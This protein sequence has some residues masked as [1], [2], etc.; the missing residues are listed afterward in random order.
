MAT[1]GLVYSTLITLD[2][3]SCYFKKLEACADQVSVSHTLNLLI[4]LLGGLIALACLTYLVVFPW[5]V[6]GCAV[7]S[8]YPLLNF[9]D[10]EHYEAMIAMRPENMEQLY[11]LATSTTI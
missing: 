6:F 7:H 5:R 4:V 3:N 11:L 10:H 8:T 9:G 2:F 1:G